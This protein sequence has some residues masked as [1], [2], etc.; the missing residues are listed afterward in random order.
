MSK[1]LSLDCDHGPLTYELFR[2]HSHDAPDGEGLRMRA[3]LQSIVREELTDRQRDCL[4]LRYGEGLSVKEVAGALGI[5]APTASKHL[6][7]ARA[8]IAHVMEL[9]FPRLKGV[10]P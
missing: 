7:K 3:A 5:N 9:S 8:R 4:R 1:P 2:E 6:K 10:R